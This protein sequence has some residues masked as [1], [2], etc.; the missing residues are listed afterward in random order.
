VEKWGLERRAVGNLCSQTLP[1]RVG[2]G[3]SDCAVPLTLQYAQAAAK[4]AH[5]VGNFAQFLENGGS[6]ANRWNRQRFALP[7]EAGSP[8]QAS[9]PRRRSRPRYPAGAPVSCQY[10]LD[11]PCVFSGIPACKL[12][13]RRPRNAEI[14]GRPDMLFDASRPHCRHRGAGGADLVQARA[15][16]NEP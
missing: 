5:A 13:E 3:P 8:A 11:N 4:P 2:A 9:N 10:I 7:R 1:A 15:C 14:L 16:G 6:A 12:I